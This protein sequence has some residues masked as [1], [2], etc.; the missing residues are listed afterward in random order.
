MLT[1]AVTFAEGEGSPR[2]WFTITRTVDGDG[3]MCAARR[4]VVLG[5]RGAFCRRTGLCSRV[6][7]DSNRCCAAWH[8]LPAM[9]AGGM[10]D[11]GTSPNGRRPHKPSAPFLTRY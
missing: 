7:L 6:S 8:A 4:A 3:V 2:H 9:R 11:P 5:D 1:Q 10:P